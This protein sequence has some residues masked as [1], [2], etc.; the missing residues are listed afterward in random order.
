MTTA[1]RLKECVDIP[2]KGLV[3]SSTKEEQEKAGKKG[4]K[5]AGNVKPKPMAKLARR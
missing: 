1:T 2:R 3:K 5:T 4:K